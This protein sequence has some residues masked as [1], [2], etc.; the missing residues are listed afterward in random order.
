MSRGI[1]KCCADLTATLRK[2]PA[3]LHLHSLAPEHDAGEVNLGI[4]RPRPRW[5]PNP[6]GLEAILLPKTAQPL[7]SSDGG[8]GRQA[9]RFRCPKRLPVVH[10][11][12]ICLPSL[13][14]VCGIRLVTHVC[15]DNQTVEPTC[16]PESVCLSVVV[17]HGDL[18][19]G[20]ISRVLIRMLLIVT[21]ETRGQGYHFNSCVPSYYSH[22]PRFYVVFFLALNVRR[23]SDL[24]PLTFFDLP[25]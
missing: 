20:A 2:T 21:L 8:D 22:V 17:I 16:Q 15:L 12:I 11:H 4:L 10:A 3:H 25:L 9:P 13:A 1:L 23:G 7:A 14:Y 18:A 5:R 19:L 6:E 24:R